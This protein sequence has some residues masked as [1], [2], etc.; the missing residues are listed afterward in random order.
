MDDWRK[1]GHEAIATVHVHGEEHKQPH[2]HVEIAAR[3]VGADGEIDRGVRLWRG[4][5]T[6]YAERQRVAD[7]VNRT[8][9]PDPPY[10]PGGFRDMTDRKDDKA[11]PRI[12]P[13]EFRAARTKPRPRPNR[14]GRRARKK[15]NGKP[16]ASGWPARQRRKPS[17]TGWRWP[18]SNGGTP[19]RRSGRPRK[20]RKRIGKKLPPW[21]RKPPR[22]PRPA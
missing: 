4:K 14:S 22:P 19:R 16:S 18:N 8:C 6:I 21:P 15:R 10:H 12:P 5:P 9:E 3:P 13:R 11:R 2:L 7:I 1:R 20:G 17:G